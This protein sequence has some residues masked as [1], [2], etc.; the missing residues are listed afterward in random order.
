MY[1]V[2]RYFTAVEQDR[3]EDQHIYKVN[4]INNAFSNNKIKG[5]T[6]LP[7]FLPLKDSYIFGYTLEL[8][9]IIVLYII[10]FL[11]YFVINIENDFNITSVVLDLRGHIDILNY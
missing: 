5:N 11:K 9:F 4:S 10:M 1:F 6:N 2:C 7:F 3:P 8:K